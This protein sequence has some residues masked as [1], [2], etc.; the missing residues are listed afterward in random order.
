MP[1]SPAAKRRLDRVLLVVTAIAV[2]VALV[3]VSTAAGW[4]DHVVTRT[5]LALF[6]VARLIPWLKRQHAKHPNT[7]AGL[8]ALAAFWALIFAT[9]HPSLSGPFMILGKLV[10]LF[11]VPALVLW[12]LDPGTIRDIWRDHRARYPRRTDAR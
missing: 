3:S 5:C 4:S 10:V 12:R 7:V 6:F 11:G 2:L 9:A 1:L 8:A